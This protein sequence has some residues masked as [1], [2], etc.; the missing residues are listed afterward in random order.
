[1]VN[2]K[3][4]SRFK[5]VCQPGLMKTPVFPFYRRG[6]ACFDKDVLPHSWLNSACEWH[7]TQAFVFLPMYFPQSEAKPFGCGLTF[8]PDCWK[9]AWHLMQ[10]CS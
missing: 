10:S 1:L 7:F 4:G 5:S 6:D 3:A 2:K 9:V 8:A